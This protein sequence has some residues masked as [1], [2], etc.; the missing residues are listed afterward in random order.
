MILIIY[1]ITSI[2]TIMVGSYWVEKHN[3]DLPNK[4]DKD[5]NQAYLVF[6]ALFWPF[7]VVL[8]AF[9]GL[10]WLLTLPGRYL[11]RRSK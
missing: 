2:F 7:A 5:E 10:W 4:D 9:Y 1:L 11:A 3:K 8:W 6:G